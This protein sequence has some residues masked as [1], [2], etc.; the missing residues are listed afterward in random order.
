MSVFS[1]LRRAASDDRGSAAEFALVLPLIVLFLLG[2]IDAGRYAY[3]FN[4]GEKA[5]QIGAR[6]AV[7]TDPLVSELLTYTFSGVS[8][9]GT[10]LGQG[11]VI[12]AN[13]LGTIS[14]KAAGC[15]CL[16]TPCLGGTLT[17]DNAA[18]TV[19]AGRIREI[20]PE[21]QNSDIEVLYSGSGLGFAGNPN[22]M[23]VAPFVTVKL[24]NMTFNS[25]VLLGS[26][27]GLPTFDYTLTMEDG[28]GTAFN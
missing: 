27:V 12:P 19:I 22:G 20:W 7:V 16:D 4:R 2:I 23:D 17:A 15:T 6:A 11:D 28:V 13:A 9:G 3:E 25:L 26:S 21:V 8:V 14:C 10:M 1:F 18:F 24:N 5:T